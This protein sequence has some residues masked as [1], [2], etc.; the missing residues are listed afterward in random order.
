MTDR[1]TDIDFL[2]EAYP[3][4]N[5]LIIWGLR[6]APKA[7]AQCVYLCIQLTTSKKN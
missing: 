1:Q 7:K 5:G 4:Q 6:F 3:P 2:K